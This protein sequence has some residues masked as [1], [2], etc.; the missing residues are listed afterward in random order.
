MKSSTKANPWRYIGWLGPF[1]TLMGLSAG[2]VS[3]QWGIVPLS[4]LGVGLVI[5]GGS[6]LAATAQGNF[7]QRRSTLSG[8]NALIATIAVFVILAVINRVAVLNPIRLDL[9][10]NQAFSLAPQSVQVAQNL[11][12]PVKIWI[13]DDAQSETNLVTLRN[14]QRLSN[15]QITYEFVDPREQP[16]VAQRLGAQAIGDVILEYDGTTQS[17]QTLQRSATDQQSSLSESRLTNALARVGQTQEAVIYLVQGHG[18]YSLQDLSE[19]V[20]RLQD[21]NYTTQPLNLAERLAQNQPAIPNDANVLIL[22]GPRQALFPPEVAAIDTYLKQGGSVLLL[23][24]YDTP[25]TD[26]SLAPLLASWGVSLDDGLVVDGAGGGGVMGVDRNTGGV[27]GFGPTAPLVT[28]Y[29]PHPITTD[30]GNGNSFYPESRAVIL[31]AP[32]GTE[33]TA[34]LL[35]NAQSWAES[36][37]ENN[38][39]YTEGTDLQGPLTLGVA[40]RRDAPAPSNPAAATPQATPSPSPSPTP[41]TPEAANPAPEAGTEAAATEETATEAATT[42]ETPAPEAAPEATTPEA[43]PEEAATEPRLVVIGNANFIANGIFSQQ[44]NGDVF[45][46]AVVWLSQR[47][48]EVLS[49]A[50]KDPTNRRIEMTAVQANVVGWLAILIMPLIGF[51][52]CGFLWWQRR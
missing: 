23:A 48:N 2:V 10:E 27:V 37:L 51:S 11:D 7:W 35:T 44:L 25:E 52:L 18:E 22:P 9:S 13:F 24:S 49:I 3:G 47:E 45:T 34:L 31:N 17:L 41:A 26:Q 42:E 46:N 32:E 39:G 14:Y 5:L 15:G 4:L 40:L 29:G 30:F 1:L 38:L 12:R 36:D 43:A 6:L 16:D 50:P 33:G 28:Q 8:T 21:R 19:A 20:D